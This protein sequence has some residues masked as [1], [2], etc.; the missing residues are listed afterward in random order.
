MGQDQNNN[1]VRPENR[2][3]RDSWIR[4]DGESDEDDDADDLHV[5]ANW[6]GTNTTSIFTLLGSNYKEC[7]K[8]WET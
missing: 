6:E 1:A 4:K 8:L 5:F 2:T 3:W 7:F